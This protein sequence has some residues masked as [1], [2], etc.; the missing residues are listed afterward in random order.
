MVADQVF[1]LGMAIPESAS[2][3]SLAISLAAHQSAAT[4]TEVVR[5]Q[6]VLREEI[7]AAV[8]RQAASI[9]RP[10]PG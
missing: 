7:D 5:W 8:A 9:L 6:G 2:V 10:D 3:P 1:G 4:P